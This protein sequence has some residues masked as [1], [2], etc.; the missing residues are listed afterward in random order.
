MED[1]FSPLVH[2]SWKTPLA[3]DDYSHMD[4]LTLKLHRLKCTV[5][6]WERLKNH[7]RKQ[8]IL[9]INEGISNILLEDSGLLSAFN[10]DKLKILQARIGKY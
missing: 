3:L 9:D 4:A 6:E 1:D 10:V 7:E 8:H 2:P 5:K